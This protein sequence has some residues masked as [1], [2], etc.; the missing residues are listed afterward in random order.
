[1]QVKQA[2]SL[3]KIFEGFRKIS[4]VDKTAYLNYLSAVIERKQDSTE[5][6]RL[7]RFKKKLENEI[8]IP[9]DV[10]VH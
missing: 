1:M 10:A 5:K 8:R 4:V 2:E 9:K 6:R 7:I 3:Q